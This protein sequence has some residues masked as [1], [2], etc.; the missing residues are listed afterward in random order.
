MEINQAK[1]FLEEIKLGNYNSF[2]D[3]KIFKILRYCLNK[4]MIEILLLI[5]SFKFSAPGK[6][7]K[8]LV[9]SKHFF[10]QELQEKIT[11]ST[12]STI[13]S[14]FFFKA[15]RLLIKKDLGKMIDVLEKYSLIGAYLHNFVKLCA[16]EEGVATTQFIKNFGIKSQ[17]Q[18][19]K[20]FK[21]CASY[22]RKLIK[23]KNK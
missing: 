1:L 3:N 11:E 8:L 9:F 22:S 15:A 2:K 17:N 23:S 10:P 18:L 5:F 13:A 20:V 12:K 4:D 21:L 14:T 6:L 7:L 16:K 19:Q